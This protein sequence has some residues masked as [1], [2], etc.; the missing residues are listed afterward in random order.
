M[1]YLIALVVFC[2]LAYFV[3]LPV[4]TWAV[5]TIAGVLIF[6]L[7]KIWWVAAIVTVIFMLA[8]AML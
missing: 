1:H 8:R 7:S 2:A 6:L 3:L 5:A 4:A